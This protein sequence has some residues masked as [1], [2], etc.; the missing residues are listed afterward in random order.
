MGGYGEGWGDAGRGI[1]VREGG[2]LYI[3]YFS[4]E[5]D[6]SLHYADHG[7]KIGGWH[8][9]GPMLAALTL[10]SES[11]IFVN[12]LAATALLGALVCILIATR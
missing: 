7:R 3:K 2:T 4:G 10:S 5:G 11:F 1:S 6:A 9:V 12:G 8:G